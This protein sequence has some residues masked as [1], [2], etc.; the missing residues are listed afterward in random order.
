MS[1][2]SPTVANFVDKSSQDYMDSD[3]NSYFSISDDSTHHHYSPPS[4]DD[5]SFSLDSFGIDTTHD[6]HFAV[7]SLSDVLSSEDSLD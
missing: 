4:S 3:D 1:L 2:S 5:D 6:S 7:D